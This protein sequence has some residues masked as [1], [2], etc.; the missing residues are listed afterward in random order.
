[1]SQK[2]KQVDKSGTR[3]NNYSLNNDCGRCETFLRRM[4]DFR[5]D[6]AKINE[7]I[8]HLANSLKRIGVNLE[9]EYSSEIH[10]KES[11]ARLNIADIN[12]ENIM[13]AM[14]PL[15]YGESSDTRYEIKR[16]PIECKRCS[17]DPSNPESQCRAFVSSPRD[18]NGSN[19]N[20]E[21]EIE[22]IILCANR[23]P[24]YDEAEEALV[25]ELVH[26]HDVFALNLNLRNCEDLAYSEVRA[27][28]EAEC[29]GYPLWTFRRWC[30]KERAT[31]ATNC[32]FPERDNECIESVFEE[33]I[34]DTRGLTPEKN[35]NNN[36]L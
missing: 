26:V 16:I 25:H 17:D 1:M 5:K 4:L 22:R 36:T 34:N 6:P 9:P 30:V 18:N 32:M 7:R 23:L 27:A 28:R 33:A 12:T 29:S 2:Y 3:A 14:S 10:T 24:T 20:S 35:K 11:E 13:H 31:K 21:A 8:R 19:G 15:S